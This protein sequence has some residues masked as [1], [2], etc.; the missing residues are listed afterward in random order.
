[1]LRLPPRDQG[2]HTLLGLI[3][4]SIV[5]VVRVATTVV[6]GVIIVSV[7]S[8]AVAHEGWGVVVDGR[9]RVYVTDIPAN[10]IWRIS[11]DG[12]LDAVGRDIHSHALSLGGDGAVYGTHASLT[13]PVVGVWRLDENG[14]FTDIIPP[15]RGFPLAMQSFLRGL[16]GSVYSAS[17]YQYPEP[18]GGRQLSLL[19]WSPNGIIDTLAG[20]KSGQSDGSGRAAQFESIDGMAWLPDGTIVV[21]DGARLRIVSV[22]GEVRSVGKPL[23]QRQWDQ[24]LLGVAVGPDR[25]IYAADFAGRVVH[26]VNGTRRDILYRSGIF[27]SPTGVAATADGIYVLE[28]PRAPLGIMGDIGVGPYLRVRKLSPDGSTATLAL[29]WG[30]H[31]GK[32][33]I[34]VMLVVALVLLVRIGR[35]RL[36]QPTRSLQ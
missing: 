8:L 19:R 18:K 14:K 1:M 3:R 36:R 11:P 16:D 4:E 27:W 30:R 22:D 26:R 6:V 24:D 12:R 5:R 32:L 20:G 23:T 31:S 29:K 28:H 35:R 9:G 13:Q 2:D 33:A 34:G 25:S 10:T 15:T 7:P 21:A 17:I